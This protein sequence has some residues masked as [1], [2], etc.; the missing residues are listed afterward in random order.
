MRQ[1]H[2]SAHRNVRQL[3][4]LVILGAS[5]AAAQAPV[6][7]RVALVIGNSAYTRAPLQNPANDAEAMAKSLK[8]LGF[9][10]IELR[11]G[12]KAQMAEAIAKLRETLKGKRGV[13]MLY[14]SGHGLQ[15]DWRN[16]MVPV[17]ATLAKPADVPEQT[18]DVGHVIEAFR[19]A[20]NRMNILVLDACRDNPFAGTASGKGLAQLDAPPGTL[21]AYSTA[22]GNVADDGDGSNGLYT[23]YLLAE[24]RKPTAKIEDVFKR[25]RLQVRQKSAGRQIPWE[26]TSLEDDFYFNDAASVAAKAER[27]RL[28]ASEE[29]RDKAFGL[30][31]ADWDRIKDSKSADD[32]YAF[33]QRYPS[34]LIGEQAQFRLDQLQKARV[35]AQ[36]G[37]NGVVPLASGSN[38]YALGDE[39]VYDLIDGYTKTARRL[40]WRVTHADNER[41]EINNGAV[42]L[43]QMGGTLRNRT[44]IKEPALVQSPADLAVGKRWS[45]AFTNTFAAGRRKTTNYYTFRV[46]AFEEVQVPAGRIM[47]FKVERTGTARD[48]IDFISLSGTSWIDPTTMISVRN[49]SLDRNRAGIARYES[50]QLVSMKRVPR[51]AGP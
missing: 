6:D 18:V 12:S 29:A 20:G 49:D 11:D 37:A 47:A 4:T 19:A 32:F 35:Q 41:V 14:Y 39:Y 43:D 36:P 2:S 27:D 16:Y 42:V 10:V 17:D 28:A 50:Q 30:E 8:S 44:G 22:P 23:Q 21:L 24:L 38:R 9:D 48:D 45:A 51:A 5:A 13:G 15:L 7:L 26:S 46:T 40:V 3:I 31:K 25:V 33:L 34:G 1:R